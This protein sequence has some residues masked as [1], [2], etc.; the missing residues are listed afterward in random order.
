MRP[1]ADDLQPTNTAITGQRLRGLAS[2]ADES[3]ATAAR[4]NLE[5]GKAL[6]RLAVL[7]NETGGS[8]LGSLVK[9]LGVDPVVII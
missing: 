9:G 1:A 3:R 5:S 6:Q 8:G 2:D 7:Q 4:T